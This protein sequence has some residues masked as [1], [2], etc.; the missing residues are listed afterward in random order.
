MGNAKRIP[1]GTQIG[2]L[3]VIGYGNP[4][5]KGKHSYGT[6]IVQCLCENKTIKVLPTCVLTRSENKVKSCGCLL[7]NK[8]KVT[9][10]KHE[11]Q[12]DHG[13]RYVYAPY[14]KNARKSGGHKGYIYEHRL[15]MENLIGRPLN[16]NEDVHHIDFN[17]LN[18][19]PENLL[20]LESKAHQRLHKRLKKM[21][22]KTPL[23]K[24]T[25]IELSR[26]MPFRLCVDCGSPL[27]IREDSASKI[28]RCEKC[29][30]I[31]ARKCQW[32]S[33]EQL[34]D[35]IE[36]LGIAAVSRKYG[37]SWPSVKRWAIKL[38]I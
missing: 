3:V 21:G 27:S 15:V 26:E 25:L 7:H 6:T 17:G 33:P 23:P 34:Q 9:T 8:K 4:I 37:V 11:P 22:I 19:N 2:R 1:L 5:V 16:G 12:Y 10:A 14:S 13:Y 38:G 28:K 18:N 36:N 32:P 35:E 29:R 30:A 24:E 20:L 31:H